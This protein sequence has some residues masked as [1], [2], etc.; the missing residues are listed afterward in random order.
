MDLAE[1]VD[2]LVVESRV[3][4][5]PGVDHRSESVEIELEP[6]D[7]A[8]VAPAAAQL[9]EEVGVASPCAC[10]SWSTSAQTAPPPTVARRI[11]GSTRTPFIGERSITIPPSQVEKPAM[12]WLPPRTAIVRLLLRAKPTAAITSVVPAQGTTTA[13]L[14]PS[15]A[16]FQIRH[17]SA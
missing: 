1:P 9:P 11:W 16:P 10:V 14:W 3:E 2:E 6:R 15:C 4:D 7:D 12:L 8:E 5:R 17:A 13:G